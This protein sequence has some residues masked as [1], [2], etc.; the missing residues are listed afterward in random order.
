MRRG[1]EKAITS[2]NAKNAKVVAVLRPGEEDAWV[3]GVWLNESGNNYI[4]Y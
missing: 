3:G 4:V 1:D 2:Q